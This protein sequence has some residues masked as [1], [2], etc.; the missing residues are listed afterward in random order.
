LRFIQ[1][2]KSKWHTVAD[3]NDNSP[4]KIWLFKNLK[5][6]I[7]KI[8]SEKRIFFSQ[9]VLYN[10]GKIQDNYQ[11]AMIQKQLNSLIFF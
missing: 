8:E 1:E 7:Y 9:F 2:N 4:V 6:F 5:F 3:K 10:C 11:L